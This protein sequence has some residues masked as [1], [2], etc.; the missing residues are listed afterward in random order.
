MKD[1][2]FEAIF[3]LQFEPG[4]LVKIE[5]DEEIVSKLQEGYG[6][7]NP[8]MKKARHLPNIF[9]EREMKPHSQKSPKNQVSKIHGSDFSS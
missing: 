8:L 7:W 1:K 2:Y 5:D 3:C 4:E 9:H 6:G